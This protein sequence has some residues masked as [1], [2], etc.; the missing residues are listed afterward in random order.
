MTIVGLFRR[1]KRWN[2]VHPTF[3]AFW[4]IGVGLG[5]GVGW[6]PGYGPEAVG[7]VG[8]GCGVGFSVGVT[9]IGVGVGLPASGLTCLPF[10][11]LMWTGKEASNLTFNHAIPALAFGVKQSWEAVALQ[12]AALEKGVQRFCEIEVPKGREYM[13]RLQMR[14]MKRLQDSS[15]PPATQVVGEPQFRSPNVHFN[16]GFKRIEDSPTGTSSSPPFTPS[17]TE[18]PPS[19]STEDSADKS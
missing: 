12:S 16:R 6:G 11:T 18:Q 14:V 15:K 13:N 8:A 19:T 7:F 4:G 17:R 10:N 2:P 1:Y 3:G 9:L 5:C